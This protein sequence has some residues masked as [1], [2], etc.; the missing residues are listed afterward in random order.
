MSNAVF[1]E[2][3]FKGFQ[4]HVD[5]T[6]RLSP[7]L[8]VITGPSDSGK[9]AVIRAIRWLF[10]G[11]PEGDSFVNRAVGHTEVGVRRSD[12]A[13]V[14]K[15]RKGAKTSYTLEM[16]GE[17]TMVFEKADVPEEVI[18]AFGIVETKFGDFETVLNFAYQLDSPF[19]ISKPGSAGA[20]VLGKLSGTEVVD[21]AIKAVAKDNYA[22]NQAKLRATEEIKKI[23]ADLYPFEDLAHQQECLQACEIILGN[24]DSSLS[25]HK[26]LVELQTTH[27]SIAAKVDVYME[28][29]QSLADVPKLRVD[30]EK[31]EGHALMLKCLLSLY[32]ILQ[33]VGL[34]VIGWRKILDQYGS[35]PTI[36]T[37]LNQAVDNQKR[38]DV[39]NNLNILYDRHSRNM[40]A[41]F[42]VLDATE[43]ISKIADGVASIESTLE[44]AQALKALQRRQLDVGEEITRYRAVID[45]TTGVHEAGNRLVSIVN[46]FEC[47]RRLQLLKAQYIA[48]S[49]RI[50]QYVN[51]IND[52]QG[53]TQAAASIDLVVEKHRR[54]T[55]MEDLR[56][57]HTACVLRIRSSD[58]VLRSTKE[59]VEKAQ[60]E[61]RDLW[62]DVGACPLCGRVAEYQ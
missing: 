20:K 1:E 7:G 60:T 59:A 33:D 34:S 25:R 29:L 48:I 51:S 15:R 8:T 49:T 28:T 38:F 54:L 24:V 32:E 22:A 45:S 6:I 10:L 23:T 13:V 50:T 43:N 53:V 47:L 16:P 18:Q 37:I 27:L 39:L 17:S 14:I 57:R 11:E 42:A 46:N 31:I 9:T 35:L 30:L 56:V 5:S 58:I 4:S 3:W 52:T 2:I 19:L 21:L 62:A 41:T 12:G 55:V 61:L 40:E 36:N 44:R 26:T